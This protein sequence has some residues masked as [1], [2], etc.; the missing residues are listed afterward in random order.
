VCPWLLFFCLVFIGLVYVVGF[1][2]SYYF[3]ELFVLLSIVCVSSEVLVGAN[4]FWLF[5]I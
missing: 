1:V 3:V 4:A 5:G 2:G